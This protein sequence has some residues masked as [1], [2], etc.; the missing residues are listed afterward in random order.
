MEDG[1]EREEGASANQ[2]T[3]RPVALSKVEGFLPPAL[4]RKRAVSRKIEHR[5]IA[6]RAGTRLWKTRK[7][8]FA[9]LVDQGFPLT[10]RCGRE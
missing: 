5:R 10:R 9:P 6:R 2:V 8:P 4:A 3:N 1:P 7:R